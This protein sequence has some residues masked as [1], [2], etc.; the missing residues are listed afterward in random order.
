MGEPELHDP[1]QDPPHVSPGDGLRLDP[2][3]AGQQLPLQGALVFVPRAFV[4]LRVLLQIFVRQLVEAF[5]E[6]YYLL[7]PAGSRPCAAAW[8]ALLASLRAWASERRGQ[9]LVVSRRN[10]PAC[11]Y[12]TIHYL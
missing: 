7:F 9:V 12:V 6:A 2:P 8:S 10:L 5:L 11:R 4:H 3:P 1:V